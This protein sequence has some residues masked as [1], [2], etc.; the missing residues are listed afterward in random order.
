MLS[1]AALGFLG[2]GLQPPIP[3]WGTMIMESRPYIM[4]AP[5]TALF[6]GLFIFIFITVFTVAGR[7][8]DRQFNTVGNDH[9]NN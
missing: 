9:A 6:P 1:I 2:L 4:R 8:L 7:L 5:W 3:E